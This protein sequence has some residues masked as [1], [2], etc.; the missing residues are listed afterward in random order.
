[1]PEINNKIIN[2][3]KKMLIYSYTK[4]TIYG[5]SSFI[6]LIVKSL[7]VK[8]A[9]RINFHSMIDIYYIRLLEQQSYSDKN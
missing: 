4:I 8:N 9:L 6:Y 1:M 2:K 5:K 3:I 7:N